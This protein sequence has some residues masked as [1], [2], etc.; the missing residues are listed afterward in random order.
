M[1]LLS[2]TYVKNSLIF[3]LVFILPTFFAY[4]DPSLPPH[5]ILLCFH[6]PSHNYWVQFQV[7]LKYATHVYQ[8]TLG[9]TMLLGF[10]L[11]VLCHVIY[12]PKGYDGLLST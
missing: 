6:S 8:M 5:D 4:I 9:K 12:L 10:F 1:N 11:F 2:C 3:K 7:K